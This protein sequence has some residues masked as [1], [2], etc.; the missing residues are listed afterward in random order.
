MSRSCGS[1]CWN[2]SVPSLADESSDDC[3]GTHSTGD[4][5]GPED[6]DDYDSW[7][8]ELKPRQKR[9]DGC[10]S[11]ESEGSVDGAQRVGEKGEEGDEDVSYDDD[12]EAEDDED[13]DENDVDSDGDGDKDGDEDDDGDVD[14]EE[15]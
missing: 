1:V 7:F 14:D 6:S 4:S 12:E 3:S 11:D 9:G 2:Q 13:E 10:S 8:D 15:W 5:E